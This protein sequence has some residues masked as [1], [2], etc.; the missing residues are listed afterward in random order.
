MLP[1][2]L[3]HRA[4]SVAAATLPGHSARSGMGRFPLGPAGTTRGAILAGVP[5]AACGLARSVL[6]VVLGVLRSCGASAGCAIHTFRGL[7]SAARRLH[8]PA[9]LYECAC[10]RTQ[11]VD[12]HIARAAARRAALCAQLLHCGTNPAD[13]GLART[14]SPLAR[15]HALL[16]RPTQSGHVRGARLTSLRAHPLL[17]HLALLDD[18]HSAG[19]IVGP[20][21]LIVR[22]WSFADDRSPLLPVRRGAQ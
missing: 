21:G 6:A 5:C 19:S 9:L 22:R 12:V 20:V 18:L 4:R 10:H 7:E 2:S 17:I 11:P 15:L 3:A 14:A 16:L 1:A 13:L 8:L